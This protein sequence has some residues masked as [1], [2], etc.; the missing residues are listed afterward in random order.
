MLIVPI[1][2]VFVFTLVSKADNAEELAFPLI[3]VFN[4]EILLSISASV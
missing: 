4:A 3:V 2:E 1:L